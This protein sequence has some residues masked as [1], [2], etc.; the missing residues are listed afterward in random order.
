MTERYPRVMV[1]LQDRDRDRT[2]QKPKGSQEFMVSGGF[3]R[4]V[5]KAKATTVPERVAKRMIPVRIRGDWRAFCGQTVQA[6]KKGEGSP[7][8]GE[9]SLG[10]RA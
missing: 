8:L 2:G 5:A 3:H 6:V 7:V 9:G 10:G 1:L 4:L